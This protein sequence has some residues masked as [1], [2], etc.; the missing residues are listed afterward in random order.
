[1]SNSKNINK[2]VHIVDYVNKQIEVLSSNI[3]DISL[4]AQ[5]EKNKKIELKRAK[6]KAFIEKCKEKKKKL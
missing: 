5:I 2:T 4:K 1:M 6:K 3:G